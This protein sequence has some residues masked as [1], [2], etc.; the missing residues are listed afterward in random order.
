MPPD[1]VTVITPLY[2]CEEFIEETIH[3]VLS[4]TYQ[5]FEYI[6]VNDGS[7][8]QSAS[9]VQ[10]I[11]KSDSRIV[12]IN[13]KQNQGAARARNIAIER[14]KGKYIAFIDS[15]DLWRNDKLSFQINFMRYNQV[16]FSFTSYMQFTATGPR[17]KVIKAPTR[18]TYQREL[19]Y[20]HV[21]TS[22]VVYDQSK[23]GKVFFPNILKRQ[24]YGM[25]LKILKMGHIG[26]GIQTCLS[27]YRKRKGSVSSNKIDMIRYNWK[28]Y[29]EIENLDVFRSSLYLS[30][31][32]L[33]KLFRI[34]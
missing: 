21:G 32:I 12:L 7:T 30:T 19:L 25:W 28:L 1:L 20:N 16:P 2:N 14:S 8:D 11:I 4:Q 24:D 6:I 26:Y 10:S 23:I 31:T 33:S 9:I 34:K 22:T 27:Q 29:R 3:S 17:K 13:N 18:L 15:D 5:D